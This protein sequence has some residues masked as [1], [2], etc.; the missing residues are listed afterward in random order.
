MKQF[1]Y[2]IQPLAALPLER[3][4][5]EDLILWKIPDRHQHQCDQPQLGRSEK[6]LSE[7][8]FITKEKIFLD[9]FQGKQFPEHI[10]TKTSSVQ[11][12]YFRLKRVIPLVHDSPGLLKGLP[13]C[14][15]PVRDKYV[16]PN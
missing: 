5:G 2:H 13:R 8:F 4:R 16:I 9:S 12:Q 7:R 15:K 3:W 11:D 1:F 10:T 14:P 6:K